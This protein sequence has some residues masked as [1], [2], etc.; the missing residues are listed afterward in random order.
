[1][2][3]LDRY[4]VRMVLG[5]TI[6]GI[7]M[8]SLVYSAF[9]IAALL[10]DDTL[11]GVP[12]PTMLSLVG[13][14][15]LIALEIVLPSAFYVSMIMS[16]GAWHRDREAYAAYASGISPARVEAPLVA[17]SLFVALIVAGMTLHVRPWSYGLSFTLQERMTQLTSELLQPGTFYRWSPHL[18][19]HAQRVRD[20][21]PRLEGVFAARRAED[22]F[23][24]IRSDRASISVPDAESRQFIEFLDGEIYEL[25]TGPGKHRETHFARLVYHTDDAGGDRGMHRRTTSTRELL[26]AGTLKEI[27]EVQWRFCIPAVTFLIGLIAIRLGHLRPLGSTYGRLGIGI[28]IYIVVFNLVSLLSGAVES[29]QVPPWPGMY[30]VIPL[31]LVIYLVMTRM[32]GLNLRDPP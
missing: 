27:A 6:A 20:T 24:V 13:V 12:F 29:G 32:R 11:A 10:R 8:V 2:T 3:T 17:L 26:D 7:L 19:I 1:M 31:L 14:R 4:L 25:L 18:V 28:L 9:V 22:R 16:F 5:P 21:E 23:Q 15:D 30:S